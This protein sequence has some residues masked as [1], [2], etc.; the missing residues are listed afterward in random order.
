METTGQNTLQWMVTMSAMN[1]TTTNKQL[2]L[3]SSGISNSLDNC[4]RHANPSQKDTDGDGVGDEC[5][6]CV[7]KPNKD[8]K[9]KDS[10]LVGDEC[11]LN[12]DSDRDGLQVSVCDVDT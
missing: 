6:N 4:P 10:D 5:D 11:D 8:Q 2:S 1:S 7:F 12:I 9:D 3:H